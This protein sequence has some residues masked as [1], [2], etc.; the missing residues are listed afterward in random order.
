MGLYE[1]FSDISQN[2][3][4]AH[5][6]ALSKNVIFPNYDDPALI[7]LNNDISGISSPYTFKFFRCDVETLVNT[8][9]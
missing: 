9:M 7:D 4:A 1:G 3:I 2:V 8:I 6:S 5:C